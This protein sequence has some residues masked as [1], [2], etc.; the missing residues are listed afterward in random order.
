MSQNSEQTKKELNETISQLEMELDQLRKNNALA[1]MQS[2]IMTEALAYLLPETEL[3]NTGFT[4][5]LAKATEN[6]M[7]AQCFDN[8]KMVAHFKSFTMDTLN[9]INLRVESTKKENAKNHK[10]S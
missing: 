8:E 6:N 2:Y 7:V 1:D 10:T 3:V 9:T 5:V 4:D